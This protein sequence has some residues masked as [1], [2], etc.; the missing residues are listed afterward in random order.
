MYRIQPTAPGYTHIWDWITYFANVDP[1]EVLSLLDLSYEL[2]TSLALVS[3]HR[4]RTIR[5]I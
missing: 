5:S 4:T 3:A 2:A 1:L